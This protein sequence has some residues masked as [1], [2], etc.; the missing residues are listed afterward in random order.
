MMYRLYLILDPLGFSTKRSSE[1]ESI[2]MYP[3]SP[4][5]LTGTKCDYCII[6]L[7]EVK[8]K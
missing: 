8:T 5:I 6:T 2:A 1:T 4:Y 3:P 7:T